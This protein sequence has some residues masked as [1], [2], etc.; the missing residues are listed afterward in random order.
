MYS[1]WVLLLVW[2]V[3]SGLAGFFLMGSDKARAIDGSWRIPEATL[4]TLA[5]AGG[6]LASFWEAAYFAT[7][8]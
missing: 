7:R 2:V 6:D 4:F 3:I 8:P 1:I 5:L